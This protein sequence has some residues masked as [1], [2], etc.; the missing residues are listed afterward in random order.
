MPFSENKSLVGS[1]I[2][3]SIEL[4]SSTSDLLSRVSSF[5]PKLQAANNAL[6]REDQD[7]NGKRKRCVLDDSLKPVNDDEFDND[8]ADEYISEESDEDDYNTSSTFI[9]QNENGKAND[10]KQIVLT[11]ALGEL[12]DDNPIIQDLGNDIETE[13]EGNDS[14][15]V[16]FVAKNQ[17]GEKIRHLEE[18]KQKRA[19][20][21]EL[22]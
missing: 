12:D 19:L 18:R 14:T 1:T 8:D 15:S 17:L 11:I 2:N 7:T 4:R 13:I 10:K 6:L 20:I 9:D 3:D 5:L 22:S 16:E 21:T